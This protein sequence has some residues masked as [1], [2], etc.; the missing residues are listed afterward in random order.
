MSAQ[1][2]RERGEEKEGGVPGNYCLIVAYSDGKKKKKTKFPPLGPQSQSCHLSLCWFFP[3]FLSHLPASAIERRWDNGGRERA[4][5]KW[6]FHRKQPEAQ[7]GIKKVDCDVG[8]KGKKSGGGGKRKRGG[9]L[10]GMIMGERIG[11]ALR[12]ATYTLTR[13]WRHG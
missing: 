5:T 12:K 11:R 1:M 13:T 6:R 4:S 8:G 2:Q 7:E 10:R 9:N 3:S